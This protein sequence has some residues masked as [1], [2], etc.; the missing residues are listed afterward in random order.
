MSGKMRRRL[1]SYG[2][3][4]QVWKAWAGWV[5]GGAALLFIGAALLNIGSLIQAV[6]QNERAPAQSAAA[7]GPLPGSRHLRGV[8]AAILEGKADDELATQGRHLAQRQGGHQVGHQVGN[9]GGP[10]QPTREPAAAVRTRAITS[11]QLP[12]DSPSLQ[13]ARQ[14]LGRLKTCWLDSSCGFNESDPRA[15]HF[16]AVENA[17]RWLDSVGRL[18]SSGVLQDE[19]AQASAAELAREWVAFPDDHVREAAIAL[20]E[21]LDKS[22]ANLD[23]ILVGLGASHGA[24]LFDRALPLL[25]VYAQAGHGEA[26][27][28]FLIDT[29]TRGPLRASEAVA[30]GISPFLNDTNT[31]R[32]EAALRR[33][34]PGGRARRRLED[35]L[36]EYSRQRTGA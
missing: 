10:T 19:R 28:R 24:P 21:K 16:E 23:A 18:Q 13:L 27:T 8:E 31:S 6:W 5:V 30:L 4:P 32:F 36:R 33:M 14:E 3:R 9:Q 2:A 1:P 26:I 11:S 35:Q 29:L 7:D 12:G 17:K 25:I 22:S 20:F 15:A 34:P